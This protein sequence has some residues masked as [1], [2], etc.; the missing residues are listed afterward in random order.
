[1]KRFLIIVSMLSLLAMS[2]HAAAYRLQL[3]AFASSQKKYAEQLVAK[4][5]NAGIDADIV[6][7]RV[8]GKPYLLFQTPSRP[9]VRDLKIWEKRAK[10]AHLDYFIR[11]ADNL[12]E[13]TKMP[14][15]PPKIK[16]DAVHRSV[17]GNKVENALFADNPRFR[18]II[19]KGLEIRETLRRNK[20]HFLE[21]YREESAVS[22]LQ[23]KLKF[24]RAV[25]RERNGADVGLL[26]NIFDGGLFGQRRHAARIAAKSVAYENEIEKISDNYV[27]MAKIEIAEIKKNIGFYY[28][29]L[30]TGLMKKMV[31]HYKR[32]L[33]AG[34]VT[35]TLYDRF[36]RDYAQKRKSLEYLAYQNYEKF[37]K[38]YAPLI[39]NIEKVKLLDIDTLR[40]I[41]MQKILTRQQEVARYNDLKSST[42]W[43]ENMKAKAYLDRKQYT[44]IDRRETLAGIELN[45]PLTLRDGTGY[46]KEQQKLMREAHR[47]EQLMLKKEIEAIYLDIAY[48]KSEI[49]KQK[50]HG[51]FLKKRMQ[52]IAVRRSAPIASEKGDLYLE[53][54]QNRLD[55]LETEQRV[56]E[57]RTDILLDLIQLQYTSGVQIL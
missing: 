12:S 56:W 40:Q 47:A 10:S 46:A 41:A 1:M 49:E 31:R 29:T 52:S 6:T 37:D 13:L 53:S 57:L 3:G 34:T 39:S 5:T 14:P 25:N 50:K 9:H 4:A 36:V 11:R 43:K 33:A 18:E 35:R 27:K 17:S 45:I 22:P 20:E 19:D 16:A 42:G 21:S 48:R 44:F 7:R 30:Q 24:E 23:A 8:D 51:E 2:I 54:M 55:M 38:R 26:W 15:A 32:A 28:T